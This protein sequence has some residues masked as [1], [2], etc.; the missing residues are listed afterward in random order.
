MLSNSWLF[1]RGVAV[2]LALL[3][4]G[5]VLAADPKTTAGKEPPD[6]PG[7]GMYMTQLLRLVRRLGF[8]QGRLSRQG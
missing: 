6:P 3:D 8:E 5:A 4:A 2:G 1:Y 7:T